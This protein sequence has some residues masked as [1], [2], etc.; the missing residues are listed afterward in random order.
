MNENEDLFEVVRTEVHF[1]PKCPCP[2]CRRE[3]ERRAADKRTHIEP[4]LQSISVDTAHLLG[5]IDHRSPQ[6]SVARGMMCG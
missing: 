1:L 3:R 6:G 4:H 2:D 5:F